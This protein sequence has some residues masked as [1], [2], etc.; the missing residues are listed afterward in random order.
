MNKT[1]AERIAVVEEKAQ[2][3][4]RAVRDILFEIKRL[5]EHISKMITE[6][7]NE[8]SIIHQNL[9]TK[10]D[11]ICNDNDERDKKISTLEGFIIRIKT[12]WY[13]VTGIFAIVLWIGQVLIEK[14]LLK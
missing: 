2:Q 13:W 14:L 9:E 12:H 11:R 7:F 3:S 10:I 8:H 6:K 5:P 4:E 1:E